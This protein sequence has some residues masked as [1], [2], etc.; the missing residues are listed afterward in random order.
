MI[1]H[2]EGDMEGR[3]DTSSDTEENVEEEPLVY[4]EDER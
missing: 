2:Y 3:P 4:A 1:P